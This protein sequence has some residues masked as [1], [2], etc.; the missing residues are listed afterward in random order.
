[1][2]ENL[3]QELLAALE[4]EA[5]HHDIDVVDVELGGA[6][7]APVVRVRIDHADESLPTI[8]LD[9]VS[10][11]SEWINAALDELDPLPGSYTLE[12]SSPG[13][14][15]PLRRPHDFERFA[16]QDVQVVTTAA[17]GRKRFTGRLEGFSEGNVLLATEE[18]EV[19]IPLDQVRSAKIKPDFNA[20]R[21]KKK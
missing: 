21:G 5:A 6:T 12:V 20:G 2:R 14:D 15:R 18:G 17:E 8:T 1:M 3:R 16:G 19:T 10:A 11:E 13:M 7:K 9:E 4:A